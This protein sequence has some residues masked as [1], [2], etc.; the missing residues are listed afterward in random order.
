MGFT[1]TAVVAGSSTAFS[2]RWFSALQQSVGNEDQ[3]G[4]VLR[5]PVAIVA[6]DRN[7]AGLCHRD[8]ANE[9]NRGSTAFLR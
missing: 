5:S 4:S 3:V 9:D 6:D 2:V 1:S 8:H 7:Q